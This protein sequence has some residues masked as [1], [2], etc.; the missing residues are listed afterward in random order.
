MAQGRLDVAALAAPRGCCCCC[1][2]LSQ[3]RGHHLNT[4]P[5]AEGAHT[6][7]QHLFLYTCAPEAPTG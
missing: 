2:V 6:P 3:E 1:V 5:A 4:E 7:H